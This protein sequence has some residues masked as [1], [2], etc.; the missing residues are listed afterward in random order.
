[1][2]VRTSVVCAVP[3]SPRLCSAVV[4]LIFLVPP[5]FRIPAHSFIHKNPRDTQTLL[6]WIFFP[7]CKGKQITQPGCCVCLHCVAPLVFYG[8]AEVV[9]RIE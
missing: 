9:C 2:T 8:D 6:P 7:A 5:P 3:L 4:E 1:M